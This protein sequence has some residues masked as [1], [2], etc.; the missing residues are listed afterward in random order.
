MA[1][2]GTNDAGSGRRERAGRSG[3]AALPRGQ[4]LKDVGG[5]LA[6]SS[7]ET[8][9]LIEILALG[10]ELD[11][12]VCG[13][14]AAGRREA[15]KLVN[16]TAVYLRWLEGVR[17]WAWADVAAAECTRDPPTVHRTEP[18]LLVQRPQRHGVGPAA[19]WQS[20]DGRM[21]SSQGSLTR[22]RIPHYLAFAAAAALLVGACAA[23]NG[24][25][26]PAAASSAPLVGSPASSEAT[27][28]GPGVGAPIAASGGVASGIAGTGIAAAGPAIAYPYPG[29]PATPGLAPDHT[30][31]VTGFG[32]APMA[33]DGSDREAAQQ[34][35]L[36]ASLADAKA[37]ADI[38]AHATGVTI[39][40]VLSVA[41]SS[42]PGYFGPVPLVMGG[43]PPVR[44]RR[45]AL[46]PGKGS[47]RWRRRPTS[48]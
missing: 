18:R 27:G 16:V 8:P 10:C 36:K 28:S 15:S 19:L 6:A 37:Q 26:P 40:G 25:T 1:Q 38:V 14:S 3:V 48:R 45:A 24:A 31:V 22:T 32:H 47:H 34:I 33:A 7:R 41:V 9:Q 12:E 35:A 23:A 17:D 29:Y 39:Q 44:R 2:K 20:G 46:H 21:V 43:A 30:I 4:F 11:Q 5:V 42:S 13:I